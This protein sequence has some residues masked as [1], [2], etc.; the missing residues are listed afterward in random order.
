MGGTQCHSPEQ[1]DGFNS[2]AAVGLTLKALELEMLSHSFCNGFMLIICYSQSDVGAR[3]GGGALKWRRIFFVETHF[4]NGYIRLCLV[5][6]VRFV[7]VP[8]IK[9]KYYD[10]NKRS[11][12]HPPPPTHTKP[13]SFTPKTRFHRAQNLEIL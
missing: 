2:I 3:G 11:T 13:E 12:L 7:T 10:G 1:M 9:A 6:M 8:M 4:N 5:I